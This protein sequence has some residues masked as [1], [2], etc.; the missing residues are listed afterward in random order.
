MMVSVVVLRSPFL[1]LPGVGV[2]VFCLRCRQNGNATQ[3]HV[4]ALVKS[5]LLFSGLFF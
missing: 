5:V 2:P 3:Y 1:A 4:I